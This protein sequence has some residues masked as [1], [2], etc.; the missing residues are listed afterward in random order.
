MF[1]IFYMQLLLK[2]HLCL[3]L[4]LFVIKS[5]KSSMYFILMAH[6]NLRPTMFQ[7]LNCYMKLEAAIMDR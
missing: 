5:L 2:N 7:V 6:L 4:F 3:F 1:K